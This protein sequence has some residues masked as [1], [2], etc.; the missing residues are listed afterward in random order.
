MTADDVLYR[1]RLR[2]LAL[3]GELGNVRAACRALGIHPS[4]YYRWKKT[5]D[6]HG[7]ELLRPR[8]RRSPRMPNQASPLTEQRVLAF[9][10]AHPG[11]GPARIASEL[12]R[13]K[14]GALSISPNGVWGV[15]RRH[16]LSTRARR[17]ALVA[18]YA[19]PPEPARAPEP[20]RHIAVARPGE[21]VQ[22]DC[23]FLGRL[24]GT[25]GAVWQYTAIDAY[26]AYLWARLYVTPRN[27]AARS[28]SLLAH[29][30]AAE[31]AERGYALGAISSDNGSA[32]TSHL[33]GEA[34]AG[35][36]VE[37]RRIHAG[38][39]QSNGFIER[40]QRTVL[41]ECWRPAFARYLTPKLTGLRRDLEAFLGY[42]N[43]DRAHNGRHTRGR[44]PEQVLGKAAMWEPRMP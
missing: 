8:E 2:A 27:P 32:L 21:L 20:V 44:T 24:S 31:L 42:Y 35:M 25:T 10:L 41:E 13:E 40:A 19:A 39:P 15:L 17:Y 34:L 16:G 9:S 28:T 3:A 1:Y 37:H 38:R 4:T 7:L 6:R 18:G 29:A 12:G 26:S 30:V 5:A 14:W 43:A 33:F 36:G 11:L 22:M 23:F